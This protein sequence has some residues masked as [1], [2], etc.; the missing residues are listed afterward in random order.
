M[1]PHSDSG[2]LEQV[3]SQF[4][5]K[6]LHIILDSRIPSILPCERT[7]DSRV[8]KSDKWF[9]LVLGDRPAALDNLNFWHRNLM[10]PMI[11]DIILVQQRTPVSSVNNVLSGS[12]G[13]T[14]TETVIERWFVQFESPPRVTAS[15]PGE[16]CAASYK[17]TYKK[18]IIFLRSLYLQTRLLPAYRI[19]RQLSSSSQSLN[20]DIIYKVS[21]FSEPFSRAE[22]EMMKEYRFV[23]IEAFPGR[24]HVSVTYRPQLSDFNLQ[25]L[26]T[27]LPKI[28]SDY[29]GSPATDPLRYFP[30]SYKGDRAIS[31]PSE[32]MHAPTSVPSQR[33][34]SW[35]SGF[36]KPVVNRHLAGSPPVHCTSQMSYDSP[37]PPLERIQNHRRP[38]HQRALLYDECQLS[39]P[40][41]LSVSP[42]T[43]TYLRNSDSPRQTRASCETAPVTIPSSMTSRNAR[44]ISP[45]FSD[46]SKLSLPPLSPRSTRL[47]HSSNE[48]LSGMRLIKKSEA[49][50]AGDLGSVGQKVLKD[51][52]DDSGRFSGP[53]SSSDSPRVGF[54]RSSSKLSFQDDID[55][56]DFS[57]PFD[58][59]DVDSP[60]SRISQ[61]FDG[62]RNLESTSIGRK[63][64]DAAVG[65]LV[66]MLRTAP[67][68]HQDSSCFS[69]RSLRAEVDNDGIATTAS[70]FFVPRR[71]SDA[72]EELRSYREM[73][74]LLLSKSGTQVLTREPS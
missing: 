6:S 35:T 53:L 30:S 67:P 17:K 48:S 73:K 41:S 70:G 74:D 10:D 34:H 63:S 26:T 43:P 36:H 25:S 7:C 57:C 33:P 51:S 56:C 5:L 13:R 32:V 19:F 22:E 59:D 46:P 23:P 40:F 60:D 62:K 31:F 27:M 64:Q 58:A 4:L 42:S 28:I 72:L 65:V 55:D 3:V 49:S 44:Y 16:G 12:S 15:Q 29:V 1:T 20:F 54:S 71:T 21:S 24:L 50:R 14:A 9:N 18:S 47:D 38:L 11:I 2:K 8:R 66:H 69:C 61:N 68:L 39:P 45:N 52:R 37:S